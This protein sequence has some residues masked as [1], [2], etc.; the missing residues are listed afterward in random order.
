MLYR[1]PKFSHNR[2]HPVITDLLMM[3][4]PVIE[5][6]A[7]TDRYDIITAIGKGTYGEV[8]KCRDRI[9]NEILA[10]K[11][12]NILNRK[13]GFPLSAL[14]EMNLLRKL[15][16]DNIVGLRAVIT[17]LP[18]DFGLKGNSHVYLAFEYCEYDLYGLLYSEHSDIF[19]SKHILSY[20]K[21]MLMAM[22]VCKDSGIVHRDI[23]P[24]NV[25]ITR[26]NVLKLG[27]FGLGRK[28]SG[29]KRRYTTKVITIYYRP[30]ELLLAD[31]NASSNYGHEVDIWSIGCMIYEMITKQ[32][33][34]KSKQHYKTDEQKQHM[35]HLQTIF[36]ICGIPSKEEWP[37]FS[38]YPA[39]KLFASSN[40]P[41]RLR[42]HLEATIPEEYAGSIDLLMGLLILNPAK[43]ISIEEA[44]K[45][46]FIMKHG[47]EP[48]TLPPIDFL[49]ELHQMDVS[50]SKRAREENS[51]RE[52]LRVEKTIPLNM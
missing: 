26:N 35:D 14:R 15:H 13:D 1:P 45:H 44:A 18:N 33:L 31:R 3:E 21:Q 5:L 7:I 42:E 20:I 17:T 50:A 27:D 39:S 16:H 19:T 28:L 23:K 51:N 24:A 36:S 47:I 40:L 2:P 22:K 9:T 38:E 52:K 4:I 37:E 29:D 25:F 49:A 41:N 46:P 32:T 10:V 34:F 12:I 43:R 8:H 6:S 11:R 30:P 48:S